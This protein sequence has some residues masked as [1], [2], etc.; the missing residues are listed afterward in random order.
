M[1]GPPCDVCGSNKR[2]VRWVLRPAE[3]E[4]RTRWLCAKCGGPVQVA[5]N[6]AKP[7]RGAAIIEERLRR[8][9]QP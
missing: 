7:T 2:V 9:S 8:K 5:Y 3:G 6:A 4:P 1:P